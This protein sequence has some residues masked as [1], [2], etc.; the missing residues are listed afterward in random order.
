MHLVYE[1]A[2]GLW[3]ADFQPVESPLL[4]LAGSDARGQSVGRGL[5]PRI[6]VLAVSFVS[7]VTR[8]W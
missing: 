7:F 2:L 8:M 1:N 3:H 6:F 5:K 4:L